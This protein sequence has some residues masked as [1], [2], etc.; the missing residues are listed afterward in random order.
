MLILKIPLRIPETGA[1]IAKEQKKKT[2]YNITI[3]SNTIFKI[4]NKVQTMV[5]IDIFI[6]DLK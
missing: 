2:I 4:S 1:N 6:K 5:N 3:C